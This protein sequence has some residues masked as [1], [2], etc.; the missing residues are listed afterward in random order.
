MSQVKQ[1]LSPT[2]VLTRAYLSLEK[3]VTASWEV[4]LAVGRGWMLVV[5][6]ER[7]GVESTKWRVSEIL[8]V[9]T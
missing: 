4:I 6:V 8:A 5:V 1:L 3:S 2:A 9:G 7:S